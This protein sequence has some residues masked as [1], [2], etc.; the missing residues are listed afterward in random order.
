MTGIRCTA[1]EHQP[2]VA[3][4]RGLDLDRVLDLI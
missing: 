1:E 2:A 3:L 4:D